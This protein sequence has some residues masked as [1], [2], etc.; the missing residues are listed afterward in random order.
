MAIRIK[1]TWNYIGQ[2]RWKWE[3]YIDDGGSGELNKI[4]FVEYV[5]HPTFPDPIRKVNSREDNF[6]MRTNGWGTFELKAFV[7]KKDGTKEKLEHE[8]QLE[9]EPVSGVSG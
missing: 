4:E 6:R 2:D 1:N 3:A 9:Y 5:L 7:Y 8:I